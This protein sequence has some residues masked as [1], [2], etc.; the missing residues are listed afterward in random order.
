MIFSKWLLQVI[1]KDLLE[2]GL[3]AGLRER[4]RVYI[5]RGFLGATVKFGNV[6]VRGKSRDPTPPHPTPEM[7]R[8]RGLW[9][10]RWFLGI[11]Y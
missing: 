9:D 6:T 4:E 1:L 8:L 10:P 3:C 11:L 7:I 2:T 5:G